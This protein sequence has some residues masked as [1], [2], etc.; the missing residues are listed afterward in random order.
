MSRTLEQN[1]GSMKIKSYFS[2]SVEKA[3]Q[4]ARQELGPEA[5]LLTTRRSP[6]ETR[7]LGAY[8]VVFGLPASNASPP[9]LSQPV[10][11][12]AELQSLQAQ[13][14]EVKNTLHWG[15]GRPQVSSA[16]LPEELWRELVDADL[17]PNLARQIAEEAVATWREKAQARPVQGGVLLRQLAIESIS[18]RLRFAAEPA[19]ETN[20]AGRLMIF[21]GPPGG[22]KTTTLAKL[23]VQFGLATRRSM[24]IISVDPH[25]VASHEKL[26]ALA[27]VLGAGFTTANSLSEFVA[28]LEEFR[29]KNLI[30]VDTPGYG[31]RVFVGARDIASCL[32]P[33]SQKEVHLVVPASMKRAD[34]S[35][36]VRQY[37]LFQPDYLL[38]T[39][40]DETESFGAALSVALEVN[41]PLSF[42]ANG[43][44]IPEDLERASS[45]ALTN[46]LTA[47][48]P[49]AAISAA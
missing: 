21:V 34:L 37:E 39:K 17:E 44:S 6:P 19:R 25:R 24:R 1:T 28:A 27:A 7:R 20:D 41:K 22:G 46:Y 43:Q 48:E 29:A 14:E 40:I 9:L 49:A 18:N 10:D 42:L 12:S 45:S 23:A 8:E 15:A 3:I 2:S 30:L 11:L 38:F 31:G 33:A 35:R 16:S 5:M 26:R 32:G 4:E 36:Y 13:L 47:R